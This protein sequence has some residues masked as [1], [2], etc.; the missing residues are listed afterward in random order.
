MAPAFFFMALGDFFLVFIYTIQRIRID[1]SWVG[2][3]SFLTAYLFLIKAYRG[4]SIP[5]RKELAALV[6]FLAASLLVT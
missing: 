2:I 4:E 3:L 6:P 5:V 1:L